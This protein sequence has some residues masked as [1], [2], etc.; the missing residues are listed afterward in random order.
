M[1]RFFS[2]PAMERRMAV[3]N[4][5]RLTSLRLVRPASSAAS[6]TRLA[7]SAPAEGG[8]GEGRCSGQAGNCNGRRPARVAASGWA[9]K[10]G[11]LVCCRTMRST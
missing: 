9:D 4:S 1:L 6:L 10:H 7:R 2:M 3:S 11:H 8:E 5:A